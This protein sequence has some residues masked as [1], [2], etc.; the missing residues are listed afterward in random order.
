MPTR[1]YN[2]YSP[3]ED[4]PREGA[5]FDSQYLPQFPTGQEKVIHL[6]HHNTNPY[7]SNISARPTQPRNRRPWAARWISPKARSAY[8]EICS[9]FFGTFIFI[10]FSLGSVAQVTL[11]SESKGDYQSIAWGFG[12]VIRSHRLVALHCC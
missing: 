12:F 1:H 9:E 4:G 6:H 10:L 5:S 3:S 7:T 8:L 2:S 11:S